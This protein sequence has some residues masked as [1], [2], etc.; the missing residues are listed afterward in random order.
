MSDQVNIRALTILQPW[1]AAIA[2]GA[3]RIET[4]SWKTDYR[5][6]LA[7]HAGNRCVQSEQSALLDNAISRHAW[8]AV[9]H[10]LGWSDPNG[11]LANWFTGLSYGAI[12]A[13]AELVDC[14]VIS[15]GTGVVPALVGGQLCTYGVSPR[16]RALGDYTP[17]RY[18]WVL[19]DVTPIT[20]IPWR[21][22]QGLWRLPTSVVEARGD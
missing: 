5:G 4:R 10:N 2:C 14:G 17:G 22:K 3:K 19:R 11:I 13:V 12:I 16:E 20:P 18:G 1:A 9:M 15:A 6:P 7:I 21:G 8:L